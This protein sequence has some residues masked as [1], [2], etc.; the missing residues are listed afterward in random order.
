MSDS[1]VIRWVK[2]LTDRNKDT[3]NQPCCDKM[4]SNTTE[5]NEKKADI[6][7]KVDKRVC[8]K[9]QYSLAQDTMLSRR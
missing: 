7:I 4:R 8:E 9:S 6:L 5:H 3:A 1:S 2:Y